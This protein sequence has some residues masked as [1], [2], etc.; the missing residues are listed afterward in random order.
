MHRRVRFLQINSVA[1]SGSTGRIVSAIGRVAQERGHDILVAYG[2]GECKEEHCIRV[3]NGIDIWLHGVKSVL[4]DAHGLGSRRA[5]LKLTEALDRIRPDVIGLH[6]IH[7][8]YLNYP[9]LFDYLSTSGIPV[10]WTLHDCWPFTGH[11]S[12]FDRFDCQ[13]WRSECSQCPMTGYYPKS[14]VDKS[15]RNFRL[16][17]A[18]FRALK[19][20]VIV[21]PS[22]WLKR[23]VEK[24]FLGG[25][26]I[27]VIHNGV[28]LDVFSP[29]TRSKSENVVL[30]VANTWDD[31]KGLEDFIKLRRILPLSFRIVLVGVSKLQKQ[32]L[33]AGIEGILRTESLTEL[34]SWYQKATVFVNPTYSDNFPTTNIE[35][36]ACGVP[37]TTYDTGGSPEAL[38]DL[39]GR[40]ISLGNAEGLADSI[41]SLAHGDRGVTS[42]RCRAR[43]EKLFNAADRSAEYVDLLESIVGTSGR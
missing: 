30:G 12:Y 38:D 7:G 10:V 20:L 40:V 2:R 8:Y 19:E 6:N 16:K 24:S 41:I 1:G 23:I 28:D 32:F 11:C 9:V 42:L 5:T 17:K 37:V 18:A 29:R 22:H 31:R 13:K 36:L 15:T 27:Q 39:T 43:A 3:G 34:V 21:T 4:G 14:I 26:P 25:F 35:A 33:P